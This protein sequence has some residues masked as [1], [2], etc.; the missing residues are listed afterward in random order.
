MSDPHDYQQTAAKALAKCAANDPWFPQPNRATVAAW[1][2]QI[3]V[4]R[5]NEADVLAG[6]TM[7]YRDNGTDRTGERFRP[8]PRD[9]VQAAIAIRRDRIDRETTAERQAREDRADAR[10]EAG[11]PAA[12]TAKDQAGAIPAP[13]RGA[14]D[15]PCPTCGAEPG[16]PCVVDDDRRGP[17]RR[18]V[19]CVR[20][21]PPSPPDV[22]HQAAPAH[23]TRSFSEPIHSHD[24]ED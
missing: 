11:R 22:E 3:A 21:C 1:A 16:Q 15:Q 7:A 13:Y 18:R 20:R 14:I 10:L 19:P 24:P 17:R 9:I 23:P 4:Y 2:E 5:L 6:V 8:L 12:A